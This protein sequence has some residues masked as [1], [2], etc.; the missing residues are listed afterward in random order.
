MREASPKEDGMLSSLFQSHEFSVNRSVFKKEKGS[1]CVGLDM[2]TTYCLN[3]DKK[4]DRI[5]E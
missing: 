3:Y 4:T 2:Y 1:I 5:I